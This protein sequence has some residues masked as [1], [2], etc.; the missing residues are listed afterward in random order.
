MKK[1]RTDQININ[2]GVTNK[3]EPRPTSYPVD[4]WAD[5][6]GDRSAAGW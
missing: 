6:K 4:V 2:A 3:G 5:D 1:I